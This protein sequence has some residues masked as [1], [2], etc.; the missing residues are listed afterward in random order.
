MS[1][2]FVS[3]WLPGPAVRATGWL[4]PALVAALTFVTFLPILANGFVNWDDTLMLIFNPNYRGLG[5]AQLKF[6]FT[7]DWSAHYHPITWLTYEVDYVIW[8]MNPKG[9]HLTSM[10]IHSATAAVAALLARKLLRR[11]AQLEGIALEV[12]ALVAALAFSV[13]PLRVEV[14]AW[15]S[16]R[17]DVV[18]GLAFFATLLAYVWAIEALDAGA[19]GRYRRRLVAALLLGVMALLS[20]SISMVLP[21]VLLILD[22][23]PLRRPLAD[24]RLWR[25]KL[26][27]VVPA[28]ATAVMA[29]IAVGR[30]EFGASGGYDALDRVMMAAHS[31]AFYLLKTVAPFNLSPIY[32][33][34]VHLDPLQWR[35]VASAVA[36]LAISAIAVLARRRAP[37]LAAAWAYH[38]VTVLPVSGLTHA[39]FQLAYDRYTY[40]LGLGWALLAGAGVGLVI[41]AWQAGALQARAVVAVVM[42]TV[43]TL[44][45]WSHLARRHGRIWHDSFSLWSQGLLLNPDSC[46]VCHH[47][48]AVVARDAGVYD[49]AE[50]QL[51]RA[52]AIRPAYPQAYINLADVLEL[53]GRPHEAIRTLQEAER[54]FAAD[55]AMARGFLRV[56]AEVEGRVPSILTPLR[57]PRRWH[58]PRRRR[59]G[60]QG[61]REVACDRCA[62]CAR[63]SRSRSSALPGTSAAA[64]ARSRTAAV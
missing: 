25:E 52:L 20:K 22:V 24:A 4:V 60:D 23:Y 14:V 55:A 1:S 12:G 13:H 45:S 34:P 11:A 51:R 31:L 15:A 30:R 27:F 42:V 19:V 37:W 58:R 57:R 46:S 49:E 2:P 50:R 59:P 21:V 54:I 26:L 16:A 10:L 38:I 47:G 63:A 41:R 62:V 53:A 3:D 18:S 48:F 35:F 6:A 17:R 36:V 33:I 39:G 43:V 5:L 40:L 64:S 44:G 32:E 29:L 7:T 56:R 8:G 61:R 9:Y 28:A